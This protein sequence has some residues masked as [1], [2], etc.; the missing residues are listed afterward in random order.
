MTVTTRIAG[1]IAAQS[2]TALRL[3]FGGVVNRI[4]RQSN[5]GRIV[6]TRD[7]ECKPMKWVIH[8]GPPETGT[9]SIQQ[10]LNSQRDVL[11]AQGIF[12]PAWATRH[13]HHPELYL[14]AART[15]LYLQMGLELRTRPLPE[16]VWRIEAEAKA[17]KCDSIVVS[18]ELLAALTVGEFQ[19]MLSALTKMDASPLVIFVQRDRE[20]FSR[21]CAQQLIKQGDARTEKI[22]IECGRDAWLACFLFLI[23]ALEADSHG[24]KIRTLYADEIVPAFIETAG[25]WFGRDLKISIDAPRFNQAIPTETIAKIH[26]FNVTNYP[27]MKL[28]QDFAPA[29]DVDIKSAEAWLR[30]RQERDA[31]AS[32]NSSRHTVSLPFAL[33]SG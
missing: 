11:R 5:Q 23:P 29:P 19:A 26:R 6:L 20:S 4:S 27:N 24:A 21:N 1:V 14:A 9:S 28:G 15:S 13:T 2:A 7:S 17:A 30:L 10:C 22:L 25:G 12:Y 8:A 3:C 33:V 18:S 16:L 32:S 31:L